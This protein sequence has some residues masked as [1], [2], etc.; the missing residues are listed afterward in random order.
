[1]EGEAGEILARDRTLP[2]PHS[3]GA[4]A[5]ASTDA[6]AGKESSG[7]A[8]TLE[9]AAARDSAARPAA[10]DTSDALHAARPAPPRAEGERSGPPA[11]SAAP[12]AGAADLIV[13]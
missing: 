9:R 5:G 4:P 8:P 7:D 1:L 10:I 3:P 13:P 12:D 2:A 6:S 11:A